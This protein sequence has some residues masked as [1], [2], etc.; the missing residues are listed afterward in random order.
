MRIRKFNESSG[1]EIDSEYIKQCFMDF[2]D[3]G[4]AR[5]YSYNDIAR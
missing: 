3:N 4:M 5:I 1:K 2:F